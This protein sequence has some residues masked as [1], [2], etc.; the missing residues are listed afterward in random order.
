MIPQI[1]SGSSVGGCLAYQDKDKYVNKSSELKTSEQGSE[2]NNKPL[3]SL[4][5]TQNMRGFLY[6]NPTIKTE[7]ESVFNSWNMKNGAIKANVF[8][9]SLNFPNTDNDKLSQEKLIDIANEFMLQMGYERVPYAIYEHYDTDHKHIHI[10]SS[11]VDI[12]GKKVKDFQEMKRAIEIAR[13]IEQRYGLTRVNGKDKGMSVT[14][15]GVEP[16]AAGLTDNMSKKA[17]IRHYLKLAL[18]EKFTSREEVVAYLK[19][20][21]INLKVTN[22][23]G[24]ECIALMVQTKNDQSKVFYASEIQKNLIADID[25]RLARNLKE[26]KSDTHVS[27]IQ[28]FRNEIKTKSKLDNL[29]ELKALL[30]K[31]GLN[32]NITKNYIERYRGN[33]F[34]FN[35]IEAKSKTLESLTKRGTIVDNARRV[36]SD[37]DTHTMTKFLKG[38]T[39]NPLFFSAKKEANKEAAD[40]LVREYFDVNQLSKLKD[41]DHVHVLS[42]ASF[43]SKNSIPQA[44]AEKVAFEMSWEDKTSD[45]KLT[46]KVS[47]TNAS[48]WQ[49]I[50]F[51][52]QVEGT[53]KAGQKYFICDDVI[54]SG[55]TLKAY[56]NH[57]EKGG[58]EVIGVSSI[59]ARKD[60]GIRLTEA[61]IAKLD[62]QFGL[63]EFNQFLRDYSIASD[64]NDLTCMEADYFLDHF[65]SV[66]E[67]RERA[68]EQYQ[69][70]SKQLIDKADSKLC[71][72]IIKRDI[73]EDFNLDFEFSSVDKKGNKLYTDSLYQKTH[74]SALTKEILERCPFLFNDQ[75]HLASFTEAAHNKKM[76]NNAVRKTSELIE[77][78]PNNAIIN[79]ANELKA[80]GM[81]VKINYER[82]SDK[83]M[84]VQKIELFSKDKA[85][86]ILIK[87]DDVITGQYK[88]LQPLFLHLDASLNHLDSIS[89]DIMKSTMT[90]INSRNDKPLEQVTMLNY[91]ESLSAKEFAEYGRSISSAIGVHI[92]Q[93]LTQ[94][95]QSILTNQRV[96]LSSPH[97]GNS[98]RALTNVLV[99]SNSHNITNFYS[100]EE[101]ENK[102]F[103]IP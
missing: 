67:I 53:V 40:K 79:F 3:S 41:I 18:Q 21:Q 57:I 52:P 10:V 43:E 32:V 92:T 85:N 60:I 76:L 94:F 17:Y 27:A 68:S 73:K 48:I 103:E 46:D 87:Y 16:K 30:G 81:E 91:L 44:L 97:Q 100:V 55:S 71:D 99:N 74:R 83:S 26:R 82:L 54:T 22:K 66:P 8:H 4:I 37:F 31:Y 80:R 20:K 50:L 51:K 39:E 7:I 25:K 86:N 23:H 13:D 88:H 69:L 34:V 28:A 102:F 59:A 84:H 6:K 29:N 62:T 11:R 14:D 47:F 24:K 65:I 2:D 33:E 70:L 78:Q 12:D 58:G 93:H 38:Y 49:R 56:I 101:N 45:F 42:I 77:Q 5:H 35:A 36:F 19:S 90:E 61:L 9:C 96:S 89:T 72:K 1:S 95:K 15:K 64:H 98:I 75:E 63:N